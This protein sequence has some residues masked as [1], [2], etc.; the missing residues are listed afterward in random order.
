MPQQRMPQPQRPMPPQQ[1]R[2]IPLPAQRQPQRPQL[3]VP[4]PQPAPQV[5]APLPEPPVVARA[6]RKTAKLNELV[7]SKH[8]L[9][10]GIMLAEVLGKPVALRDEM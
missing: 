3:T 5:A 10:Q 7:L 6:V 9:R 4:P 2:T 8:A 1:Q